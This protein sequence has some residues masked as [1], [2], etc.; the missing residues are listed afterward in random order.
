MRIS[1]WSSDVCSSDLLL[2]AVGGGSVDHG[3]FNRGFHRRISRGFLIGVRRALDAR[4][5]GGL[6]VARQL[7]GIA[8]H[9]P[10]ALRARDRALDE[11]KAA[12]DVGADAFEILLGAVARAHVAGHLLVLADAARTLAV[13]GPTLRT[14]AHRHTVPRAHTSQSTKHEKAPV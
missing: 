6:G 9:Q 2:C 7:H 13:T 1:A 5:I 8:D 3:F 10:A 11:E 4:R 14:V 12:L